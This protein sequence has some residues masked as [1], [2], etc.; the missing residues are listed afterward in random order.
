MYLIKDSPNCR[1]IQIKFTCEVYNTIIILSFVTFS[2]PI[3]KEHIIR[4]TYIYIREV[5]ITDMSKFFDVV[6]S[7]VDN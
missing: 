5:T 1:H 2:V 6:F 7:Y 4:L 3:F